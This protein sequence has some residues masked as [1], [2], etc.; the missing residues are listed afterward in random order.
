ME[1][2]TQKE[3]ITEDVMAPLVEAITK[4]MGKT[5]E[6]FMLM[7]PLTLTVLKDKG[8]SKAPHVGSEDFHPVRVYMGKRGKMICVFKPVMTADYKEMEMAQDEAERSLMGFKEFLKETTAGLDATIADARRQIAD[9]A[10]REALK[11]RY[12]KY[13]DLGFGSW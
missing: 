10:E 1:E 4:A 6:T 12:D 2:K 3:Q 7:E 9:K 8:Y 11:D 13:E 5:K